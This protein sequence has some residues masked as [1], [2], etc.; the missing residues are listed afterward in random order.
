METEIVIL[1]NAH[2]NTLVLSEQIFHKHANVHSFIQ[3]K[4]K[5][6]HLKFLIH[7]QGGIPG[8]GTRGNPGGGCGIPAGGMGNGGAPNNGGCP[9]TGG[10]G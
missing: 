8:G 10:G 1:I 5:D 7:S 2:H 3:R 4:E 6:A 9:C